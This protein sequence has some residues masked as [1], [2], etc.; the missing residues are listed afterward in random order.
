MRS[1]KGGWGWLCHLF[2]LF[3]VI[4]GGVGGGAVL[5]CGW[6][7][8]LTDNLSLREKIYIVYIFEGQNSSRRGGCRCA[9]DVVVAVASA[10]VRVH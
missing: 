8:C 7:F 10:A 9:D 4:K 6:Y 2:L 3:T 5:R 1:G